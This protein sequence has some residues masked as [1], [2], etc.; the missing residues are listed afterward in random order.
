MRLV[1]LSDLHL[2][3]RQ[4]QRQTAAGINQRE[5]DIATVFR[6]VIDRVIALAPE[7]VVLA[8][9][10][11]HNVRP[12][13]PA[14]L[15]AWDQFARLTQAL[16]GAIVVM[17]AGNHDSP[18]SAETGCILRLFTPLGIHVVDGAAQRLAFPDRDLSILAVPDTGVPQQ[19][20]L[21]PD[22]SASRNVLVLHGEVAGILPASAANAERTAVE[23]TPEE[24]GAARWAYV[25][26][27]HYHVF[28]QVAP[29]AYYSG[30]L[31]YTS[32]NPWGELAE[33]KAAK[34]PG[35]GFLEYDLDTGKRTFHPIKPARPLVDLPPI[36]GRGLSAAD[37]DA[38]ITASVA[39]IP[40]GI[41][42]KI[43]RQV[44]RDVPRHVAREIDHRMLRDLKKR[45]LH[46]HLDTRRPDILRVAVGQGA[47]GRRASLMETVRD[48][49]RARPLPAGIDRDRLVE[50]GLHYLA[51]AEER[52]GATATG[53]AIAAEPD[54]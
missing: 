9:D 41:D 46:F 14:I 54:A 33:E 12:P 50:R 26:L 11:F 1:H 38:A 40:G 39:R 29:N 31:D 18:R 15:H 49:L 45:A 23:I 22:P 37:L 24:L 36:A 53:L 42:D 34:L 28:R 20:A 25:A 47:A 43:V 27:G 44:V 10:I 8:G 16:P 30:S 19:V 5:A 32:A 52:E 13:N 2:G 6:G 21:D 17:V 51:D 35:K 4:F 3:Y 48:K 7:V